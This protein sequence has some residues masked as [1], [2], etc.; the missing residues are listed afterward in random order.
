MIRVVNG[1]TIECLVAL[2]HRE[3]IRKGNR[4]AV[5]DQET[6]KCPCEGRPSAYPRAGS[7]L[8]KINCTLRSELV[9]PPVARQA[10]FVRAP[11]ELRRL[12]TFAHEAV[13][14]P[15]VNEFPGLFAHRTDLGVTF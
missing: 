8:E 11:T 5:R 12:S 10:F 3:I 13:D 2:L 6:V 4:L 9:K 14:G 7:R 1:W 15:C